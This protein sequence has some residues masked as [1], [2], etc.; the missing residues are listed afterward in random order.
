MKVFICTIIDH[1]L[2]NCPPLQSVYTHVR[3]GLCRGNCNE[4]PR[5]KLRGIKAELRRRSPCLRAAPAVLAPV[6]AGRRLRR[7]SS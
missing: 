1:Q 5:S 4:A 7:V 6:A 2:S 3:V